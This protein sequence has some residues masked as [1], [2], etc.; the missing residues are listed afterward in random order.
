MTPFSLMI[1]ACGL[2]PAEA[3]SF[4]GLRKDTVDQWLRGRR[5]PHP[6][7]IERL[8]GLYDVISNTALEAVET[9][10]ETAPEGEIEI[11]YPADDHEALAL[12][13]PCVGAWRA[14]A[15]IV[16]AELDRPVRL[17]PRGSTAGTAA[18]ADA[19][20]K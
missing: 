8:R 13:M 19:H 15:A 6:D 7:V 5:D 4:F 17:V 12:G 20:G 14:M 1:Q 10:Q 16:I 2:S 11:G 9:I 3:A 18:A